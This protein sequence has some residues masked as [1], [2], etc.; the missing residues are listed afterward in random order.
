[1]VLGERTSFEKRPFIKGRRSKKCPSL[2]LFM[3]KIVAPFRFWV[4]L[5][6]FGSGLWAVNL[7]LRPAILKGIID[8]LSGP[9]VS[10]TIRRLGLIYMGLLLAEVVAFR[11]YDVAWLKF[12][13]PLKKHIIDFF[14]KR[15]MGQTH[16]FYQ[17]NPSGDQG[18]QLYDVMNYTP[19]C[20]QIF[21][22]KIF[23]YTLALGIAMI[24]LWQVSSFFS[25]ALLVWLLLFVLGSMWVYPRA[26][27]M[28]QDYAGR[29]AV[30]LGVIIDILT[31][32]MS[33]RFFRGNRYERGFLNRKLDAL[34]GTAQKRD[35]F[36]LKVFVFQGLS[37]LT[38]QG[39]CVWVLVIGFQ[40]GSY[41]AGDFALI[42]TL[43]TSI[44][45]FLWSL[46]KE[47][48]KI[49]HSMG[50]VRRGLALVYA[51]IDIKDEK[52]ALP[53][54]VK[55][56]EITFEKVRFRYKGAEPLFHSNSVTIK[57]G[58]KIG[59]VGYSGSGKTTFVNLILR[60][61]DV[62][63]GRILIDGQDI[64]K[65]TQDSLREQ[66]GMIPQNPRL[67]HRSVREN[68]RYGCHKASDEDVIV[69]SKK[70]FSHG[71]IKRLPEGYDTLV[72]EGGS[73]LSGGQRQRIAI[74]RAILKN[75]PILILDE[76]TSALD[77]LTE[78]GIQRSL[79][80][81]MKGKTTLVVA[82][83]L[84]T[85]LSMDRIFVFD[86]G[87]II[88]E[89]AHQELVAQDTLYKKLWNAQKDDFLPTH[90]DKGVVKEGR[91]KKVQGVEALTPKLSSKSYT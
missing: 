16:L 33:V 10:D 65:V 63:S 52:G 75:S 90:Q 27:K 58:E 35:W 69:A 29:K 17:E 67:F 11:L 47:V 13:T 87:N 70:A 14:M 76:A 79:H 37:F 66:V 74:A 22:D 25:L 91:T 24:A 36:L 26:E 61:F 84:T 60:L 3:W 6:A 71:F 85:L 34:V 53:L 42:L 41:S 86:K 15:L 19:D 20:V 4:S 30:V 9:L 8:S 50:L 23:G 62:Q 21:I 45:D 83:R 89:G 44:I 73:R 32:M 46:T 56:G 78:R 5:L 64:K 31:N 49:S 88:E 55:Q 77:V 40:R 43:N 28:A 72:G 7:S 38:Y 18:S 54:V 81:V 2:F 1:M 39:V 48:S 12:N 82:H 68:I 51:P 80:A 59:L 57:P